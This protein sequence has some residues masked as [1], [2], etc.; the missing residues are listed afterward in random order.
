MNFEADDWVKSIAAYSKEP[1]SQINNFL[2]KNNII[3]SPLPT[4]PLR[5]TI[6]AINFSGIKTGNVN[7]GPFNFSW[8][9]LSSGVWG[10]LSNENLRGKSSIIE[11]IKWLLRGDCPQ[12]LQ[13]DVK[14]WI[15]QAL[16]E[17]TIG[18]EHYRV[19]ISNK[20][21][22][23][24]SLT[25]ILQNKHEIQLANFTTEASFKMAMEAFFF[26]KIGLIPIINI[27][28]G[29]TAITEEE[30]I[31]H[32]WNSL[33]GVMFIGTNYSSLFG[34]VEVEGGLASR[35]LQMFLGLPWT[36]T[37]F[38]AKNAQKIISEKEKMQA[39]GLPLDSKWRDS[40]IDALEKELLEKQ[41]RLVSLP[42][43]KDLRDS[44]ISANIE[45]AKKIAKQ[46]H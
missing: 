43:D 41:K 46:D 44:L 11:I 29:S 35:L 28:K 7:S 39:Q 13:E 40:R 26:K 36:T 3:A 21:L 22:F 34:D 5:L 17:F 38:S 4:T 32:G 24:G 33:S 19:E 45:Y 20:D 23:S 14:S 16:L 6:N 9:N 2:S 37:L 10:I 42:P 15:H 27:K 30:T 1:E 18:E 25:K 12:K 8:S 31:T